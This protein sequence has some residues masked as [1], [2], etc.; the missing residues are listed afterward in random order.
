MSNNIKIDIHNYGID[1]AR[2]VAM[3][4]ICLL[5]TVNH[6]G[7]IG[8]V[9]INSPQWYAGVFIRV[10]TYSC[11]N[12]YGLI[13]GIVACN[14]IE[15]RPSKML[16]FVLEVLTYTLVITL[17][18]KIF[19]P[20][21]V[22]DEVWLKQLL[23]IVKEQYWY[24]TAY[25]GLLFFIPI[26]ACGI[27]YID[28][29]YLLLFTIVAIYFYSYLYNKYK[30]PAF[31]FSEGYTLIWL[32]ILFCLGA[33]L[34]KINFFSKVPFWIGIIMFIISATITY[35]LFLKGKELYL[36]Y[37]SITVLVGAISMILVL[38]NIK[39]KNKIAKEVLK[40]FGEATLGVYL[41]HV[42][43][44]IWNS[45][46]YNFT[47]KYQI[48][49]KPVVIYVLLIILSGICIFLLCA[50]CDIVRIVLVRLLHLKPILKKVDKI[51]NKIGNKLFKE[52]T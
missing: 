32:M 3:I 48:V 30:M 42:N 34:N 43:P 52:E 6:G 10:I 26:I 27:K 5:H 14:S 31:Q 8:N 51:Y 37:C 28:K 22:T 47:V 2:I 36:S 9:E 46:I 24:I 16:Y 13:S 45:V 23:P 7:A 18:Y 21:L 38:Y 15:F 4:M 50:L 44:L 39:I 33:A 25:A 11:V 49:N 35:H 17:F 20:D 40:L 19:N 1:I 12:I 29:K 41:I